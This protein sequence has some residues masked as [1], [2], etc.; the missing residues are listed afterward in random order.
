MLLLL[1]LEISQA[2]LV[3]AV[4]LLA[5]AH[6]AEDPETARPSRI[7]PL[8]TLCSRA[9]GS[10]GVFATMPFVWRGRTKR[11]TTRASPSH[12]AHDLPLRLE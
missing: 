4:L 12:E 3:A 10:S 7:T 2:P 11:P 9:Q 8:R 1:T 6:M 5:D